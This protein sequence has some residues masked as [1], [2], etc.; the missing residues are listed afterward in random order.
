VNEQK[1]FEI[2]NQRCREAFEDYVRGRDRT[3]RVLA[4]DAFRS[5]WLAHQMAAVG[6]ES[7]A[8]G[9]SNDQR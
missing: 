9:G 1:A 5:G 6:Y 7:S 8:N 3:Q 2:L 4:W